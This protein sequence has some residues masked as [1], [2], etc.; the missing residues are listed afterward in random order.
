MAQDLR[1]MFEEN[2]EVDRKRYTLKQG[3]SDRFAERL[4][5]ELPL[6]R[7]TSF[8]WLMIAAS[9]TILVT[10][11]LYFFTSGGANTPLPTTI[12]DAEE[13]VSDDS[14]I[15]LGDLSPDLKKV[16]TYYVANIN[17]AL[18]KLE[19]SP[20]SKALVDSFMEQLAGLDTE[21]Q[22]LNTELNTIGPNDQTIAALI[23]N[24]Q[25]KLQLLQKLKIKLNELKSSKNEQVEANTI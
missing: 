7:K 15:S 6:G 2:R 22:K 13:T 19:V 18:S 23:K 20:E 16:E 1:K 17:L 11:G 14:P 24:L 9:V 10:A 8:P 5:R 21:Y 3:H 25:L 12:V 4:D